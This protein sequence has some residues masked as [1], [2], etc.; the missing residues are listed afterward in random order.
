VFCGH[1][2]FCTQG[3]PNLCDREGLN[4]DPDD[5]PRLS[6]NREPLHQFLN[7]SS[8]AEKLLIHEHALVKVRKD[9]PMDKAALIGCGVTTGMGAVLNTAR[10][11]AGSTVAVIGCGGIGLSAIQGAAIAGANRVIA[12]DRISSKL[13][14]AKT[15]GAT[16][17]VNSRDGD[18][19]EQVIELTGGG[20]Q[21]SFE[22]VGTKVTAEQA[23]N[24]LEKGGTATLIGLVPVGEKLELDARSF[25][26]E[27]R[28]QGSNMGS[29]RFRVDMP[30]YVEMYLAGRLKLDEM[31]T[32][33]IR[34]E[35]INEAFDALLEGEVARQVIRF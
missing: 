33:E 34:L 15:M 17:L 4:R 35:E 9:M 14:L 23:Y 29:N 12:V 3:R 32:R 8:Y 11:P 25:I 7:L 5:R 19:V 28:I 24:M 22:A 18:P 26:Q 13:Q 16:D 21:F 2:R 6:F 31:I 1:C 20:V 27:R 30:N 10:V